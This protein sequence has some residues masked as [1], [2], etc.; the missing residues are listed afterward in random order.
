MSGTVFDQVEGKLDAG[1][2]DLG[3]QEV[4]NIANP[5]RVYRVG[6]DTVE[7]AP[8]ATPPVPDKP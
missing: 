4:K 3:L 7:S 6:S 8:T 2:E 5:V 1:F